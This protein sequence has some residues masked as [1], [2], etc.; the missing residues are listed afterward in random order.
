MKV[1]Q[2][3]AQVITAFNGHSTNEEGEHLLSDAEGLGE[4]EKKMHQL[5]ERLVYDSD[6]V[7]RRQVAKELAA[8]ALRFMVDRT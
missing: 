1:E 5:R 6:R 2:A 4:L 7:N 3:T 8:M